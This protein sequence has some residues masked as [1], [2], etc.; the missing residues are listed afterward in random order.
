[1]LH[2]RQSNV[3][4]CGRRRL[5]Y[6]YVAAWA[7]VLLEMGGCICTTF[8]V[9]YT[10]QGTVVAA[11]GTTPLAGAV[12]QL[13]SAGGITPADDVPFDTVV[14]DSDGRFQ[15]S[16]SWWGAAGCGVRPFIVPS[17]PERLPSTQIRIEYAG[18]SQTIELDLTSAT[19]DIRGLQETIEVGAV[20][21]EFTAE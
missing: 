19:Q 21:T 8:D 9:D 7:V 14:T 12:I 18:S 15:L 6:M 2:Y 5:T 10:L 20:V 11:D 17:Y 4:H 16:W 13:V 3:A 1:M